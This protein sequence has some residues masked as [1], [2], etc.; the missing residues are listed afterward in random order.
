MKRVSISGSP[1]EN[2]GKKDAKRLRREGNVICVLYGGEE[3]K[4]FT[5][6]N[7]AFNK[8]IFTPEVFV[9]DIEIDGTTYP[10]IL[11]ETQY[12]PVSDITLHAD[13][14]LLKDD[15]PVTIELPIK[16]EG[17]A[18]GVIKGGILNKKLRTIPVRGLVDDMPDS[19]VIDISELEINNNIKVGDLDY[20]KLTAQLPDRL[21]VVGV[22]TARGADEDEE[23]EDE[24]GEGE[25]GE[26]GATEATPAAE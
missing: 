3:Q 12:H 23:D 20:G 10:A 19:F 24:E 11:Q 22:K 17:T 2:V 1:R 13:F 9:I 7:N 8:L 14:L 25:E 26:E 5:I 18:P 15:K 21:L 6:E 16:L 4:H